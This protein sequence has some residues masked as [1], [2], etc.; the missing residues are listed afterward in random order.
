MWGKLLGWGSS[1]LASKGIT[2]ALLAACAGGV[3]YYTQQAEERGRL[4]QKLEEANA[5]T[6]EWSERFD[7]LQADRKLFAQFDSQLEQIRNERR[8]VSEDVEAAIEQ[9]RRTN[10]QVNIYLNHRAPDALARILCESG[11][12]EPAACPKDPEQ[13]LD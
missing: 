5:D 12:V 8:R 2:I 1:F 4:E 9:L 3:W 11:L 10:E 7:R 6:R 13:V